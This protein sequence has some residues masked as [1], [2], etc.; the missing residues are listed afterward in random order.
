MLWTV[1]LVLAPKLKRFVDATS[2][3]DLALLLETLD[4]V[5]A[6]VPHGL[7]Q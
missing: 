5:F 6:D 3:L 4:T 2:M 1:H 7:F